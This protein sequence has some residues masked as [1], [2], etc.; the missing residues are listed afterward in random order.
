MVRD[1][2]VAYTLMLAALCTSSVHVTG[3]GSR[4]VQVSCVSAKAVEPAAGAPAALML[5]G[6]GASAFSFRHLLQPIADSLTNEAISFDRPAFGCTARPMPAKCRSWDEA[7]D[8]RNPYTLSA[9]VDIT[10]AVAD[11]FAPGAPLILF[12]HSA[13]AE[14]AI[15]AA[16]ARPD[17]V[18]ALVLIAPAVAMAPARATQAAG[19]NIL[20]KLPFSSCAGGWLVRTVAR[21]AIDRGLASAWHDKS[22]LTEEIISG[23]AEPLTSAGPDVGRALWEFTLARSG[24]KNA[25]T[26]SDL[27]RIGAP[28]LII[29]GVNDKI[30][31]MEHCE[32][33]ARHIA[34]A[35]L[36]V[37][38][39][40]GHLPH[41]ERPEEVL[42]SIRRFL[43]KLSP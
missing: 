38:D 29:V 1:T 14:V 27:S 32:A 37:V 24:E 9:A 4:G 22:T 26:M 16:L 35:Q 12:G 2:V 43:A 31:P 33:V 39:Q 20:S 36:V 41:E 42:D 7:I 3:L 8:G 30:V 21:R 25:P 15:A 28:C 23:Y 19:F 10:F 18:K 5:H 13:G 34:G 40:S 6:F 17:R 11:E